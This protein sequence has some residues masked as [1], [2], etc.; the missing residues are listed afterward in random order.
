MLVYSTVPQKVEDLRRR[1][2]RSGRGK[3]R[4]TGDHK[5]QWREGRTRSMCCEKA[6]WVY[7]RFSVGN[8]M[9]VV[10][11]LR[12]EKKVNRSNRCLT[13]IFPKAPPIEADTAFTVPDLEGGVSS[14]AAG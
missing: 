2:P 5:M 3:R 4:R 14:L 1:I 9:L 8:T 12:A 13:S 7:I 6:D 11:L 10:L